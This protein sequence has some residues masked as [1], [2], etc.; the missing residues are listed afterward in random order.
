MLITGITRII[1]II[2]I[3]GFLVAF[4][5]LMIVNQ[6][7]CIEID[8]ECVMTFYLRLKVS[9]IFFANYIG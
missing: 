8:R 7:V 2:G 4:F 3:T 9:I 5:S 1:G 6:T